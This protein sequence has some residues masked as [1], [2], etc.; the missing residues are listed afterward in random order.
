MTR[1]IPKNFIKI[2]RDLRKNH[3]PWEAKLWQHLRAH[4]FYGMQFK[5]QVMIG[6]YIADFCCRNK[7]LIIE[8]DGSQHNEFKNQQKDKEKEDYFEQEGYTVLRFWN[9][10]IDS[11]LAGALER[12]KQVIDNPSPNLSPQK[13][14]GVYE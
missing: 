5:R 11:N 10:E 9:N 14:R 4:R 6:N 2:T 3:T 1:T 8:L 12:I 7:R 13:E